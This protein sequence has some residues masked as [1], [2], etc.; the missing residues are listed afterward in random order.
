MVACKESPTW[1]A[2]GQQ[3]D[4]GQLLADTSNRERQIVRHGHEF[5][6]TW[7][8][9]AFIVV[10]GLAAYLFIPQY[11]IWSGLGVGLIVLMV[12]KHVGILASFAAPTTALIRRWTCPH[13][14]NKTE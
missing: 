8:V 12:L 13:P 4:N 10:V 1:A 3:A 7:I 14:R 11:R 2:L 9:V 5:L 6:Q